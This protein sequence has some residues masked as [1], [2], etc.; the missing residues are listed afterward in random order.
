[1]KPSDFCVH[2]LNVAQPSVGGSAFDSE[3]VETLSVSTEHRKKEQNLNKSNKSWR[4]L[5]ELKQQKM[6][7]KQSKPWK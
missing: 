6:K 4:D 3:S 5:V 1:M 2:P 7:T